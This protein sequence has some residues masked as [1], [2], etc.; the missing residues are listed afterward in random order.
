MSNGK[1]ILGF[2]AG[3]IFGAAIGVAAGIMLA[4]RSGVETRAMVSD[5][6]VDAWGNVVDAYQQGSTQVAEGVEDLVPNFDARA[7]ELREK[8]DQARRRMDQIRTSIAENAGRVT[9]WAE[10]AAEAAETAEAQ[11]VEVAQAEQE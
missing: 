11:V 7:D 9:Q 2:I 10:D 8:V 1:G 3:T 6:A 5:A 4:P